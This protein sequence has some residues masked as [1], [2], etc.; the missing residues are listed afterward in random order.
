MREKELIIIINQ[1]SISTNVG[2]KRCFPRKSVVCLHKAM[3]MKAFELLIFVEEVV[4]F[5]ERL[6]LLYTK[7]M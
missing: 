3:I 6:S 4:V 2:K 5:N 7:R 1:V